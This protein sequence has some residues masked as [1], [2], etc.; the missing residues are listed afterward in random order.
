M[1]AFVVFIGNPAKE[2]SPNFD[3]SSVAMN[4]EQ[5][6]Q[7]RDG[8]LDDN[9]SVDILDAYALAKRIDA[10]DSAKAYDFNGDHQI[11]QQDIDWIAKQAVTLNSG[12]QG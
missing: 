6:R 11:D 12:E 4:N 3:A 1:I 10:G 7:T 2:K 8:D 5:A 9:G